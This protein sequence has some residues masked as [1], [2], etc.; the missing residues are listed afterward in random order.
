MLDSNEYLCFE[1]DHRKMRFNE[2][3]QFHVVFFVVV[4][5]N[6]RELIKYHKL[7]PF[8]RGRSK[9]NGTK[10]FDLLFLM[11]FHSPNPTFVAS[12]TEISDLNCITSCLVFLIDTS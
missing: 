5:L 1:T 2:F 7:V 9:L 11:I 12:L 6:E 4:I 8:L 10:Y 3:Y